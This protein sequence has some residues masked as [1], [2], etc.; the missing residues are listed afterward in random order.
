MRTAPTWS[1]SASPICGPPTSRSM[2]ATATLDISFS[3]TV[4]NLEM[5]FQG[6]VEAQA[7]D[8]G[9]FRGHRLHGRRRERRQSGHP[10]QHGS[11]PD[12]D[13]PGVRLE[14]GRR[15]VHRA[16]RS[17]AA[18]DTSTQDFGLVIDPEPPGPPVLQ[19]GVDKS[20]YDL[21]IGARYA[22]ADQR[23]VAP[24]VQRRPVR[25]RYRGHLEPQRLRGLPD[26]PA[27]FLR[28]L[29]ARRNRSRGCGRRDRHRDLLWAGDRV[30][31][32]LLRDVG[33]QLK[34]K[35]KAGFLW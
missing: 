17:S 16:S 29:Q 8:F 30:R 4:E 3:D 23:S 12:G 28:R 24:G 2:R 31:I 25:G 32:Q 35:Q 11:R 10:G 22:R 19:T 14:P 9:G 13:G 18:C 26:R 1:G 7:E 33:K 20:Y 34:N 6:H 5:G 15:A 21:L 27:S